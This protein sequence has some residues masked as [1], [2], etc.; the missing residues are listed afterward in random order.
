MVHSA[1]P[2]GESFDSLPQVLAVPAVVLAVAVPAD[3]EP[4]TKAIAANLLHYA[5]G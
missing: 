2:A 1:L 3:S 4:P 5:A